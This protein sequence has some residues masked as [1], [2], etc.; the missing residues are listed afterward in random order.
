MKTKAYMSAFALL[1]ATVAVCV[2]AEG[3]KILLVGGQGR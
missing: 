3:V 1:F 2:A